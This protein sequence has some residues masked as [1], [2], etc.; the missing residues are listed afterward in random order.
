MADH[1]STSPC[2]L[3]A[4]VCDVWCVAPAECAPSVSSGSGQRP[5]PAWLH[6]RSVPARRRAE[7]QSEYHFSQQNVVPQR[8]QPLT[9]RDRAVDSDRARADRFQWPG[10]EPASVSVSAEML[11]CLNYPVS[12]Q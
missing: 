10:L 8:P 4:S 2:L 5:P 3:I 11:L 1:G 6:L 9:E 7:S 12:G